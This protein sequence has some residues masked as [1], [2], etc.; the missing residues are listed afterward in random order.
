MYKAALHY[1]KQTIGESAEFRC[2]QWEAIELA[3]RNKRVLV[4]QQTG[5]GK[6]IVYF[7]AT[8]MLR[9]SGKGPT[10]LISPL[11]A[12][13]RNQIENAKKLGIVAESI[14]SQNVD[15]WDDVKSKLKN[16]S[17]DT[18]L[19]SPEQLANRARITEIFSYI[20]KGIG[21]FVVDEAHCISDWGHDFRPITEGL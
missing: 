12:L 3:L 13:V 16:D 8:K 21:M 2:G 5:W 11:L 7:I 1:L 17:C 10:I 20:R 6:S 19:I 15:E 14:N 9:D 18:L 4:V